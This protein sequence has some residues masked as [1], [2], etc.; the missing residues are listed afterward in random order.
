MIGGLAQAEAKENRVIAVPLASV[1]KRMFVVLGEPP[2]L[3]TAAPAQCQHFE[4]A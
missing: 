4:G 1:C 3:A 2:Y